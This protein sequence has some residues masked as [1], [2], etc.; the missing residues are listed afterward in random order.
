EKKDPALL[1][2]MTAFAQERHAAFVDVCVKLEEEIAGFTPEEKTEFLSEIGS[3]YTGLERIVIESK[4]LM[5]LM[6]F[7][8]AGSEDEVRAWIIPVNTP[9]PKAA[10]KIHSDIERGFIRAEAYSFADI[11]KYQ[12]EKI[13]KE[14]GLIRSEGKEYI[15][16]DGD[17]CFFRF[18]V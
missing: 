1:A 17:I 5:G 12:D 11:D 8:T 4:K 7:F 9:A 2:K 15:I 18:N 16:Q 14:K 13:L 10:G 6:E 3:E